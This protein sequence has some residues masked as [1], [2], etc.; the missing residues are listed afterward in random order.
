MV[1]VGVGVDQE[2]TLGAWRRVRVND[3]PCYLNGNITV[4]LIFTVRLHVCITATNTPQTARNK[5]TIVRRSSLFFQL[6]ILFPS[7]GWL[8]YVC[9]YIT[10]QTVDCA[11]RNNIQSR[12]QTSPPLRSFEKYLNCLIIMEDHSCPHSRDFK[13]QVTYSQTAQI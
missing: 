10:L 8:I 3:H 12:A 11:D 13:P 1:G 7:S 4:R 5:A 9:V 2:K 6:K